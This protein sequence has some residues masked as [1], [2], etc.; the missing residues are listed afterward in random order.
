MKGTPIPEHTDDHPTGLTRSVTL[1]T[2][3][4]NSFDGLTHLAAQI[5]G[6]PIALVSLVDANRQWFKATVGIDAPETP[7][8][9]AFFTHTIH[10]SDLLIVP[11]TTQDPRF[12]NDPCAIRHSGGALGQD[13][14]SWYRDELGLSTAELQALRDARTI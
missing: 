1:D 7:C 12:A 9:I 3:P 14:D 6:A 11:D 8:N 5:C 13:N 4:E 10:Q 2:D